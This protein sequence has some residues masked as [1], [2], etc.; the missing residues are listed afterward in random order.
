MEQ[1]QEE[2]VSLIFGDHPP[3]NWKDNPEF[4]LY[5]SELG[6]FSV[7]RISSEPERVAGE[8]H[9]LQQQ[10]RDLAAS[11][12]KTFIQTSN[13]SKEIFQEFANTEQHL[14]KLIEK[15]PDFTEKCSQFQTV[16]GDISRHRRLTSLTLAKHTSLL[17]VLELPQLMETVVRNQHYEEALQLHSYVTKLC[18]KQPQVKIL[19]DIATAVTASM[20]L[21]LQQLLGQLRAPV[22]LPQCLKVISFLRRMDVF[23]ETELRLK[24]LQARETWLNSVVAGVPK[25]DPYLHLTRTMEVLRVHLFDIVTQYRSIFSDDVDH[26]IGVGVENHFD[27]RLLFTSWLSKKV[28]EFLKIIASDLDSG[29]NSFESIL[30]QAMYFGLSFSRVGF[31]FRPLLAPIFLKAIEKQFIGKLD[32]PAALKNIS[33]SLASIEFSRLPNSPP[34]L[35]LNHESATPPLALLDFPPLAHTTNAILTSLNEIRL[36]CP[37]S[38]ASLVTTT[39]QG[40]L[41][42]LTTTL[43]DYQS[44]LGTGWSDAD[45]NGFTQMCIATQNLLLPYLQ[46]A[47]H[48]IFPPTQLQTVTGLARH[49]LVTEGIGALDKEKIMEPLKAFLPV[50][51][52]VP[53]I[54]A[55]KEGTDYVKERMGEISVALDSSEKEES[56]EPSVDTPVNETF[57]TS[58]SVVTEELTTA[59]NEVKI[60]VVSAEADPLKEGTDVEVKDEIEPETAEQ[61]LND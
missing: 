53:I 9:H 52:H 12:Y 4:A 13:C 37:L 51:E 54:E 27:N 45:Q 15:L 46:T 29:I 1:D 36:V 56:N 50:V 16:A 43:L 57:N 2:L 14:E 30:G 3:E 6:S 61:V 8:L 49:D 42:T 44:A 40:L 25:D 28:Q 23:G 31:D 60:D 21:M 7:D 33:E 47:L 20:R 17:E 10:T 5:L 39:V 32:S 59:M 19:D 58:G 24:F 48:A 34:P 11:N 38:L 35:P 26:L 18:K 41:I 22:Q 55:T